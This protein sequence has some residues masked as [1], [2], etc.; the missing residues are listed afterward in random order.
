[1]KTKS[2][3]LLLTFFLG[4]FGVHWF[5]L[6]KS[7]KGAIYLCIGA[8]GLFLWIPLLITGI[9]SLIDF[10]VI[11]FTSEERFNEEFNYDYTQ[12]SK[13][14]QQQFYQN[15][16]PQQQQP[17]NAQFPDQSQKT[18]QKDDFAQKAD[19]LKDLKSLLDAGVLTQDEF[20][21]EKKKVL[22]S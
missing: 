12:S 3:A 2:V 10:I 16:Q 6:G 19:R 13:Y 5:Y 7:T 18:A 11:A 22:N 20:D 15:P 9:L 4:C 14:Q 17:Q 21:A 8:V 1:M